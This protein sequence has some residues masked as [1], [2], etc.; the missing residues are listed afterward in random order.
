VQGLRADDRSGI[1]RCETA[2]SL[3]I[4]LRLAEL[5]KRRSFAQNAP[6][7]RFPYQAVIL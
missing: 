5:V 2:T 3:I 7:L 6:V 1:D 4:G